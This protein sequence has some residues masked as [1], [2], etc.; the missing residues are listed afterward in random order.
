MVGSLY[1]QYC[2]KGYDFLYRVPQKINF[3]MEITAINTLPY[4]IYPNNFQH[5]SAAVYHYPF[6]YYCPPNAFLSPFNLY[7]E[8]SIPYASIR[9]LQEPGEVWAQLTNKV[10]STVSHGQGYL[11]DGIWYSGHAIDQPVE[12]MISILS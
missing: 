8:D 7:D 3:G 9:Y 4:T 6:H 2:I 1:P 11:Y 12:L 10:F 5:Y